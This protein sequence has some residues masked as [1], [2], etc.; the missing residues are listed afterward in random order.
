MMPAQSVIYLKNLTVEAKHGVHPHEKTTPQRFVFNLEVAIDISRA[1]VSDDLTDTLDYSVLRQTIID[2][3]ENNSFNL[4]E[5][6]AQVIAEQ[7]MTDK[8]IQELTLT[9]DKPDALATGIPGIQ[10]TVKSPT[11]D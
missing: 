1:A 10:L 6:L 5:H 3:T 9:I 8:R 4:L 2:T 7:I 11:N